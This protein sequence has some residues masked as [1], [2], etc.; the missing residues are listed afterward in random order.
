MTPQPL[1]LKRRQDRD[2][3]Y[4]PLTD[5]ELQ[6]VAEDSIKKLLGQLTDEGLHGEARSLFDLYDEHMESVETSI[7]K[8]VV[9]KRLGGSGRYTKKRKS[10]R[11][12]PQLRDSLPTSF[13]YESSGILRSD[14]LS[15]RPLDA[16]P[17]RAVGSVIL[18]PLLYFF[19]VST[20]VNF[21]DFFPETADSRSPR[22]AF[23]PPWLTFYGA[24]VPPS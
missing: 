24:H 3:E 18:D 23:P 1:S 12:L 17:C 8:K 15:P 22:S 14:F 20:F 2:N 7:T 19:A 21:T 10:N 11:S 4:S 9:S 16:H 5:D 6:R 13:H